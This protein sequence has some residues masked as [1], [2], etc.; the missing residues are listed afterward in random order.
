MSPPPPP[1]AAAARAHTDA[2]A[3][4]HPNFYLLPRVVVHDPTQLEPLPPQGVPVLH[5]SSYSAFWGA[6]HRSPA[7]GAL[8]RLCFGRSGGW[9]GGESGRV[10]KATGAAGGWN[11]ARADSDG[12][13]RNVDGVIRGEDEFRLL[14]CVSG[15]FFSPSPHVRSIMRETWGHLLPADRI[16]SSSPSFSSSPRADEG[17]LGVAELVSVHIRLGP[18]HTTNYVV[19]PKGVLCLCVSLHVSLKHF[20]VMKN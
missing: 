15:A 6:L 5:Y 16:S 7:F 20:P 13:T 9:G 14:G 10:G 19:L 11:Y 4:A 2:F 1:P 3:A 8:R 18:K 17:G 12:R